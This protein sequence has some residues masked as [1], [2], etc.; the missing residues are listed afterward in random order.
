MSLKPSEL[1]SLLKTCCPSIP[2][3]CTTNVCTLNV[4]ILCSLRFLA[5][6]SRAAVLRALVNQ[7][8]AAAAEEIVQLFERTMKEYGEELELQRRRTEH[9][10]S[11]AACPV[12]M[13][14]FTVEKVVPSEPQKDLWSPGVDHEGPKNP[15]QVREQQEERQTKEGEEQADLSFIPIT[16]KVEEDFEEISPSSELLRR[17]PEEGRERL[18]LEAAG[19]GCHIGLEPAGTFDQDPMNEDLFEP[20]DEDGAKQQQD[21]KTGEDPATEAL[22]PF[23]CSECGKRF[24][25][26]NYL[27][28]HMKKHTGEKTCPFCGK[29]ISKSSNFTTHLRV[30]TGEKPFTCEVCRTSFS[31][32]NTLVNHMRVHTGE[33]PFSCAV[34]AKR[35]T[36]KA[37]LITHMAVHS[38]EKPFQCGVCDKR[39]TWHS[40]VKKHKCVSRPAATEEGGAAAALVISSGSL[41]AL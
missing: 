14:K 7:R 6:M 31:L 18:Q 9:P 35:F 40:Q 38:D 12:I 32:R 3:M 1:P 33:K 17:K 22:K 2:K 15:A 10:R 41:P 29:K 26:K 37:N 23:S 11:S 16:V 30:H 36:N 19:G 13:K 25:G 24:S 4:T 39:F 27:M 5:D 34:C 28:I 21:T 20:E 8:L